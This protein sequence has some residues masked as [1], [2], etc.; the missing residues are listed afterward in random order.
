M[1]VRNEIKKRRVI[2]KKSLG[3]LRDS[4]FFRLDKSLKT[5]PLVVIKQTKHCTLVR[6]QCGQLLQMCSDLD[7]F[8][9]PNSKQHTSSGHTSS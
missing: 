3:L 7:V 4:S 8:L 2:S 6:S 9:S 5:P 1:K